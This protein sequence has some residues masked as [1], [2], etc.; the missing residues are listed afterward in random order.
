MGKIN[1]LPP[2]VAELIAAGEVIDR[3]ASIVKE[4][5]E[6]S[7]DAGANRIAVELR[8]G[9]IT[10]LRVTDN[11]SGIGREDLPV[12]FVRH[13]TSKIATADD[14]DAIDAGIPRRSAAVDCGGQQGLCH[15]P[16][17]RESFG[18]PLHRNRRR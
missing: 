13:A 16:N 10:Y 1:L 6:N 15:D 12:A 4:L 18:L 11:G 2:S 3:P 17:R 9:G 7:L 8:N 5:V 14:L